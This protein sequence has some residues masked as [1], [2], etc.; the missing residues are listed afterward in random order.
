MHTYAHTHAH[1]ETERERERE[2]QVETDDI[3]EVLYTRVH[4]QTPTRANTQYFVSI[5]RDTR[6]D[7]S[8]N[9]YGK[10][11]YG[12]CHCP[13]THAWSFGPVCAA[14]EQLFYKEIDIDIDIDQTRQP[15]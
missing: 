9:S 5:R 4:M 2:R 15:S 3:M 7:D 11:Q 14:F 10:S 12:K 13:L 8:H 1:T 6:T